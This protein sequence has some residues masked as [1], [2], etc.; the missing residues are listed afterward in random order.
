MIEKMLK[1]FVF[2]LPAVFEY[3]NSYSLL[4]TKSKTL[5]GSVGLERSDSR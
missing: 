2:E 1:Y 5:K 4:Q 3:Q